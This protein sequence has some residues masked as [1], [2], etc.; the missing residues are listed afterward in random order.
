M[1]EGSIPETFVNITN[2]SIINISNNSLSGCY[3]NS[4]SPL[5]NSYLSNSTVS[6]GNDFDADWED[7]CNE[8]M[9]VC[10]ENIYEIDL[11][12]IKSGTYYAA[13]E[14]KL[15]GTLLNPKSL[16]L[17]TK[18][19][20]VDNPNPSTN[21]GNIEIDPNGCD[22][23]NALHFDGEND[24]L[25]TAYSF[26]PYEH[27]IS[28][29]MKA[30]SPTS[31]PADT[32]FFSIFTGFEFL[33]LGINDTS[34][35]NLWIVESSD[36]PDNFG[37][38]LVDDEWHHIVFTSSLTER[39]IYIDN[40]LL[41]TFNT[42]FE[43]EST[44]FRIGR[45]VGG[46]AI[47]QYKGLIDEFRVYNRTLSEADI[48]QEYNCGVINND[49]IVIYYNFDE[50]LAYEDNSGITEVINQQGNS[51]Y[52]ATMNNFSLLD[53]VSNFVNPLEIIADDC[54]DA[55]FTTQCL[56]VIAPLDENSEVELMAEDFDSGTT[57]SCDDSFTISF[58][59]EGLITSQTFDC[60][61]EGLQTIT[62]YYL[63]EGGILDTCEAMLLIQDMDDVCP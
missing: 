38:T 44:L 19:V 63:S 33:S 46:G 57:L 51:D 12:T 25:Q 2:F 59:Q 35:Y 29:W 48:Y 42:S 3:P 50:G 8:G 14:I 54:C 49:D 16:Q 41:K 58:D 36:G 56:K 30:S 47:T 61:D 32:R 22:D 13:K 6:D 4:F 26:F 24:F 11:N 1:I 45:W 39:K 5:C 28:L 7:Y 62:I 43:V 9:G 20:V 34:P 52:N 18:T 27:S 53:S 37:P 23:E 21:Q 60:D 10:C 31:S 40:V 15:S 55:T 17:K